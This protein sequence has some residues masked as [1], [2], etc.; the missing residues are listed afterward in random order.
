MEEKIARL[1]KF[2]PRLEKIIDKAIREDVGRGDITTE[3]LFDEKKKADGL[4]LAE[5]KCIVCGV[6]IAQRVFEKLDP[7]TKFRVEVKDGDEIQPG[8]IVAELSAKARHILT[9]ERLAIN[10]MQHLSGIATLT[11]K[12]VRAV[13]GTN[14]KIAA[15]RKTTPLLRG[16]EKYAV[17]TGGG[18]AHRMRL[19]DGILIKDNH[20]ALFGDVKEAVIVA[21]ANAP[22]GKKVEVEV[23]SLGELRDALEAKTDIILLDNMNIEKLKEA[24][25]MA[26]GKAL[27]EASGGVKLENVREIAMSGVDF[28]SVGAL[29][30]SAPA[31]HF[32]MIIKK[33]GE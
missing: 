23:E 29:T 25:K 3:L 10:F 12:F 18:F 20:L 6:Y 2:E 8:K 30:H 21:K 31:V 7:S 1:L 5:D 9:G 26:K 13:E 27:L 15:T 17:T 11:R 32:N 16:L 19:D 14:A 28:I 4:I 33:A 22:R 24:V